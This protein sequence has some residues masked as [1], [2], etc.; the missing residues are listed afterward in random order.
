MTRVSADP[1]GARLASKVPNCR[2][3]PTWTGP[4]P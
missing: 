1:T 3:G 4:P 2:H